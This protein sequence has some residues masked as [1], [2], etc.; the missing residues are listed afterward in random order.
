MEIG[1]GFYKNED[2]T[3]LFGPNSVTGKGFDLKQEEHT[4]YEYP[5]DGWSWFEDEATARIALGLPTKLEETFNAMTDEDKRK[6]L[7]MG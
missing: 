6:L 4:S 3:L 2:G 7:G 1:S 5:I